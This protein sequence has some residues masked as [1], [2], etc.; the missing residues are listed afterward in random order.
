M[1]NFRNLE[2]WTTRIQGSKTHIF[3]LPSGKSNQLCVIIYV[4]ALTPSKL[5]D[6][7]KLLSATS[8]VYD[9]NKDFK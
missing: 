9:F 4:L 3:Y 5:S 1:K 8:L 2:S 6:V 7:K